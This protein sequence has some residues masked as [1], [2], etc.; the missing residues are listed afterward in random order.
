MCVLVCYNI[1]SLYIKS[2]PEEGKQMKMQIQDINLPFF[3]CPA[4]RLCS[5]CS[6]YFPNWLRSFWCLSGINTSDSDTVPP[7]SYM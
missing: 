4:R 3:S 5:D 2:S 6:D 1:D 7:L